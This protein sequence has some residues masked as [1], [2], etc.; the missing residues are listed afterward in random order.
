V[1]A[2][3]ELLARDAQAM[4]AE[5]RGAVRRVLHELRERGVEAKLV[6][7]LA[8]GDFLSRSD[9][10][11]LVLSYPADLRPTIERMAGALVGRWPLDVIFLD[12]VR[13]RWRAFLMSEARDASDLC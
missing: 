3:D 2:L 10:D 12:D 13:P 8:R 7:S 9:I 1:T 11:I 5:A 6:G 4:V